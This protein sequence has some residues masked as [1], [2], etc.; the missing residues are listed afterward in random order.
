MGRG[1]LAASGEGF[2]RLNTFKAHR[3]K[4]AAP[5]AIEQAYFSGLSELAQARRLTPHP[6][7]PWPG[8]VSLPKQN[9]AV[10][11]P[12]TQDV[13]VSILRRRGFES[14]GRFTRFPLPPSELFIA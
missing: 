7:H 5:T 3:D 2:R 13:G 4:K 6:A 1:H 14:G 8:G 12:P 9:A 10:R 11:C